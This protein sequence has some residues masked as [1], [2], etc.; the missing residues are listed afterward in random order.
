MVIYRTKPNAIFI[1]QTSQGIRGLITVAIYPNSTAFLGEFVVAPEWQH[2]GWGGKLFAAA[3]DHLSS[4]DIRSIGLD[5]VHDQIPTYERRGFSKTKHEIKVYER[6]PL[7]DDFKAQAEHMVKIRD[8]PLDAIVT[9]DQ[10]N[11][12]LSRKEL[13]KTMLTLEVVEG[14]GVVHEDKLEAIL[15]ARRTRNGQSCIR[16][17]QTELMGSRMEDWSA[18]C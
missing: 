8:V 6:Q 14:W 16:K 15:I 13:W 17:A 12:G 18:I 9:M 5:A 2:Q 10:R 7:I 11:T 4:L 1:L 3:L